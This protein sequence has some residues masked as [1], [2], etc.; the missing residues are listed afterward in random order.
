MKLGMLI[1]LGTVMST[2][3]LLLGLKKHYQAKKKKGGWLTIQWK[4]RLL[5]Q[6]EKFLKWAHQVHIPHELWIMLEFIMSQRRNFWNRETR[7][8]RNLGRER[9]EEHQ[10]QVDKWCLV[11]GLDMWDDISSLLSSASDISSSHWMMASSSSRVSTSRRESVDI[12]W[13]ERES[14]KWWCGLSVCWKKMN[15]SV[16][17]QIQTPTT[18]SGT[19]NWGSHIAICRLSVALT[20]CLLSEN[21]HLISNSTNTD[22]P[23]PSEE[24]IW[25]WG[26]GWGRGL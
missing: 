12:A 3:S 24:F 21:L 23:S 9:A 18:S 26:L 10:R 7:G 5:P 2:M 8:L 4:C 11:E 13:R 25:W 19:C 6:I 15:K 17:A 20:Q 14:G 16:S 1:G 22:P